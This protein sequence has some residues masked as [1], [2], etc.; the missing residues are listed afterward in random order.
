MKTKVQ[1]IA[2]E[3]REFTN[4]RRITSVTYFCQC[5]VFGERV[6]VG[7]LRVSG[8]LAAPFLKDEQFPPGMYELEY[9]LAISFQDRSIGGRLIGI[10]PVA[11]SERNLIGKS[12]RADRKVAAA[13]A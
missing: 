13:T 11:D 7:V 4:E 5:V 12:D 2:T 8:A 10:N 3:R 6:E 9:G 1:I